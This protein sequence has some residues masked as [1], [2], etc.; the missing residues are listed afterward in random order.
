MFGLAPLAAAWLL[1]RRDGPRGPGSAGAATRIA[2]TLLITAA[3]LQAARPAAEGLP[4]IA[5]FM[6]G[7][8]QARIW[9][10]VAAMSDELIWSD[11]SGELVVF[12]PR[13][14]SRPWRLL[15]QGAML[16]SGGGLPAGCFGYM[17][18]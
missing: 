9:Q 14:G 8:E 5:L 15:G 2:A 18:R 11:P 1:H 16:V 12:R 17:R 4:T 3:G 13:E 7:M 6:P 10:A